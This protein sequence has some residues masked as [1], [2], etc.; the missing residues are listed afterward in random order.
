MSL[1]TY[2]THLLWSGD[3][4]LCSQGEPWNDLARLTTCGPAPVPSCGKA[5]PAGGHV[6]SMGT[7]GQLMLTHEPAFF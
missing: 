2:N 1:G 4:I 5:T 3:D 7:S 6:P